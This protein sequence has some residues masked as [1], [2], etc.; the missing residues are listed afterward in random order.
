MRDVIGLRKSGVRVSR[1]KS[2]RRPV[3]A[4][5]TPRAAKFQCR[6]FNFLMT[7]W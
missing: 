4:F 1:P 7:V 3:F 2:A 5:Q 6:N